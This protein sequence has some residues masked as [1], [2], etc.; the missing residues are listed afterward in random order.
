MKK[1]FIDKLGLILVENKKTLVLKSRGKD[2]WFTPGGK[3]EEGEDDKQALV[4][5]IKEELSVDI[6]PDTIKLY[7]VFEAQAFG[8]PEGTTVRITCYSADY[9]GELKP[10]TEIEELSWFSYNEKNKTTITGRLV[11]EDLKNKDLID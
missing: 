8:K 5:E 3:R 11:F 2:V 7:G 10:N 4:R 6:K 9:S 1:T